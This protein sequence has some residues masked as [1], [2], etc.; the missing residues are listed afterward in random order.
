MSEEQGTSIDL[1]VA[2]VGGG[3]AGCY[4][5]WRMVGADHQRRVG[6]FELSDRIGGRLYSR[7]LPGMPHVVAELGGMRYIPEAQALIHGLIEHLEL[8]SRPFL[9]GVSNPDGDGNNL[10]FLRRKHMRMRDV[11][12]EA[13]DRY[14]MEWHERGKTPDEILEHVVRTYVPSGEGLDLAG[15]AE[16]LVFGEP[17]Y[18]H[19]FWNLLYRVLSSEAYAFVRDAGG[20]DTSVAN[21]NAAS[22][23]Q[24]DQ[25]VEGVTYRT[26]KRGMDHLPKT[27]ARRFADLV[28]RHQGRQGLYL[29]HRLLRFDRAEEG[30]P[31]RYRLE[32]ADLS[33]VHGDDLEGA[34]PVVVYADHVVLALP[35]RGLELLDQDNFFFSHPWM[36]R[37]LKAVIKQAAF[38]LF[39]GYDRPWWRGLGLVAGHSVTD[40]PVR[41]TFYFPTEGEQPGADPHNHNSLLMASYGDDASA[42]F[43]KAFEGGAPFRGAANHFVADGEAPV[44]ADAGAVTEAMVHA[45]QGLLRQIHGLRELPAPYTAAFQDWGTDPHGAAWHAW[46][47]GFRYWEVM[48][49]MRKPLDPRWGGDGE[50]VPDEQVYIC[51]EAY[52]NVQSWIEGALQ[53]TERMLQEHFALGSPEWLDDDY[54]LGP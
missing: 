22:S 37:H 25:F 19:G 48:K 10:F 44:D 51:G 40:L 11:A 5:A 18:C 12:G 34:E 33:A 35:R 26:L 49:R 28:E 21:G 52:S 45:I 9:R 20:Y 8:P 14:H 42:A 13:S 54:D 2:I 3:V 16:R 43:W 50:P 7:H 17:L 27:L 46:K 4:S 23:L 32:F 47:A 15:K 38:K 6:L 24:V 1:E 29:G 31:R 53:T 30:A 39:L 41:Q 36:Q